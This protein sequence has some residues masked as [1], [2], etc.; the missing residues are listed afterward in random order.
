[1][2]IVILSTTILL[3]LMLR[4]AMAEFK[5]YRSVKLY[6]PKVWQA[7]G[8]PRALR[9]T[10]TFIGFEKSALFNQISNPIVL[11]LSQKNRQAGIQFVAALVFI[12]SAS[13]IFFKMA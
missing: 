10:W 11:N 6:E 7:L 4:S 3:I 12:L 8:A 2:S 5:F 1:M 13:I 9:V